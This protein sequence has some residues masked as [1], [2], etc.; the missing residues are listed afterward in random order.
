MM[1]YLT[2]LLLNGQCHQKAC[3]QHPSQNIESDKL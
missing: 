2:F 1:H 3:V